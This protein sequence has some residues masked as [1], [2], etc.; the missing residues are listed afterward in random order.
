[1][2]VCVCV[3]VGILRCDTH[4]KHTHQTTQIP[5]VDNK[6]CSPSRKTSESLKIENR[7]KEIGRITQKHGIKTKTEVSICGGLLGSVI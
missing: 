3:C 7:E 6:Y 1:M 4:K 2:C 5:N